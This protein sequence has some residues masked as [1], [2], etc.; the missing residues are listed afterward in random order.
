MVNYSPAPGYR[1]YNCNIQSPKLLSGE[2][3]ADKISFSS[4]INSGILVENGS[5]AWNNMFNISPTAFQAENCC[6]DLT[7]YFRNDID[8]KSAVIMI[9]LTKI[10][11]NWSTGVQQLYQVIGN[12][13]VTISTPSTSVLRVT[14]G[15]GVYGNC[16]WIYR[17]I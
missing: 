16:S 3:Q 1:Y 5:L 11:N 15:G 17:G 13:T 12:V 4:Y 6:G 8:G 9:G 14:I 7:L 2:I 10:N